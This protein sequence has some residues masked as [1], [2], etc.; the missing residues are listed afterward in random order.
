MRIYTHI[1]NFS[2]NKL[3]VKLVIFDC[4]GVLVDS[5]FISNTVMSEVL[6]ALGSKTSY[7]DCLA[8]FLGHSWRDCLEV[9]EDRLQ[10]KMPDDF[11]HM[12]MNKVFE[13]FDKELKPIDGIKEVLNNIPYRFCVASSGPHEKINKTL[14][15][16]GLIKK[17]KGKIYSA[18]DVK[19]GKPHPDLF[20]HAALDM[21]ACPSETIVVEDS[22]PGVKAGIAAGMTVLAYNPY[23][24]IQNQFE[25]EGAFVFKSMSHLPKLLKGLSKI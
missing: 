21:D 18:D 15:I 24:N 25:K 10:K 13:R 20:L 23:P 4:D 1:T 19:R 6:S 2:E 11:Y 8:L 9:I 14:T 7:N 12:Y 17:F 5:E 3:P 22:L 16:T